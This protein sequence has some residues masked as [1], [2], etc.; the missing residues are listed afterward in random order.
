MFQRFDHD[1][2][3][4]GVRCAAWLYLP[5]GVER[6]PVVVMAHGFSGTRDLGLPIYAERFAERGLASFVFDYRYF[7]ESE[8]EPRQLFDPDEQLADWRA[9]LAYVRGLGVVDS[10]RVGL[11]GTSFSGGHVI[12]TAA[13][14]PAVKATVAQV[15]YVGPD[16]RG[17]NP[18]AVFALRMLAATLWDRLRGAFDLDPYRIPAVGPVGSFAVINTPGSY[19]GFLA[20]V[21]PETRWRNEV[22]ARGLMKIASYRPTRRAADVRCPL[23]LV[24][25][26]RDNLIRVEAVE[27]LASRAPR[28]RLEVVDAE[29]FDVYA[30]DLLERLAGLEGDFLAQHLRVAISTGS[31]L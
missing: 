19:E 21:P 9:A 3:S 5:V 27:E 16:A 30:G 15:P 28:A 2:P 6:P 13:D 25:A 29:H 10:G 26:R 1:F 18:G 7:G 24:P 20:L 8:G 14:D 11:W 22:A 12:V 17:E 4:A 31:D 23:L